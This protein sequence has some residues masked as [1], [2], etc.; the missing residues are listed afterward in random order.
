MRPE[1]TG[2]GIGYQVATIISLRVA[3]DI[4]EEAGLREFR[5]DKKIYGKPEVNFITKIE[6][7]GNVIIKPRGP[8]EI[9][10][11]FGKKVATLKMNESA[12]AILPMEVR[13]FEILW[14]DNGLALGKYEAVMSLGYGEDGRK[15]ISAALSFWVLPG[16]FVGFSLG[17]I[18]LFFLLIVVAVKLYV[19]RKLRRFSQQTSPGSSGGMAT[20]A[21]P[22][23][24]RAIIVLCL[25]SLLLLAVI[26]WGFLAI[27]S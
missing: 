17:G 11:M 2:I 27:Y 7:L 14:Q 25:L 24:V 9:T 13:R 3:G 8:V 5:T 22:T 20:P 12:A 4:A 1:T 15:T 19:R 18:A 23:S 6:N 26:I 16:K 21:R 10:N